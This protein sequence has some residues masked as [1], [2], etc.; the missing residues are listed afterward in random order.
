[1]TQDR[2]Y[3]NVYNVPAGLPFSKIL[4]QYLVDLSDKNGVSLTHY[5][6][7]LPTRRACRVLRDAFLGLND[8]KPILLPQM[9]PIGDVD[10]DELSILTFGADRFFA[11]IPQPIPAIRRQLLLARL[12]LQAPDFAQGA[13][14]ALAL[15]KALAQFIDQIIVEGLDVADLY[16]IVPDDFAEHWK[17]TLDF[18]KIIS[19]QWPMILHDEG[20]VDVARRRNL[21]LLSLCDF[22]RENPPDYP[23]IAAGVTGSVP[24]VSELL[25]VIANM[26]FGQVI[27]PG[28][29]C[30]M[31]DKA[32]TCLDVNHPQYMLKR[33]L[34]KIGVVR[35]DVVDIA[36]D[37]DGDARRFL[38]SQMMLPAQETHQ[39]RAFAESH[40]LKSMCSD[41]Q[42]YPCTTQGEEAA[43]IS[44]IMRQ[45][46]NVAGQVT[47]LVTPDRVLA[48]RVAAQCRQW[49]IDV[50]DS[51]GQSL[52]DTRLGKFL[53]LISRVCLSDYDP[54]SIL[55]LLKVSY[56]RFGQE[57]QD[58]VRMVELFENSVLR[59]DVS[60][61]SHDMLRSYVKECGEDGEKL[62]CFLGAF[63]DVLMPL[64][65]CRKS[66]DFKEILRVHLQVAEALA[67]SSTVLGMEIL[68]QGD[69]GE[70]GSL[71]FTDLLLHADQLGGISTG[72]Y[73]GLVSSLM[74]G[75]SVRS[76]YNVHPR[77]LIL[78]QLEA[79]LADFDTVIMGGLNE[80]VWPQDVGH[81]PWMSR[82]MRKAYGLPDAEQMIGV[83]AHDFVQAFCAKNVFMTRAGKIDGAPTVPARWLDRLDAVLHGG[84]V[85][86]GDL[87]VYPYREWAK[88]L[89]DHEDFQPYERPSPRPPVSVRPNGVSITKFETWMQNP[90][91]IYMH[92]ILR[93]R[94]TSPLLQDNDA[95]LRGTLT[96]KI[97]EKFCNT[98]PIAL[99]DDAQNI[100]IDIAKN[101]LRADVESTESLNY[102]WPKFMRL[103]QWFVSH[104]KEWR[105][106]A[107]FLASEV[108]GN[109]DLDI[110]GE[111][112]NIYGVADRIDRMHG[113]Y[114]LI[115][116]KTGAGSLSGS[117]IKKG[118]L[119]QLPL[120]AFILREGGF[121]GRGFKYDPPEMD[122]VRVPA[123]EVS[124][125][126]YW[127]LSGKG[128]GGQ[129]EDVRDDLDQIVD[130][131]LDGVI[132]LVRV[133][134]K[135]DTP[136]LC[137]PNTSNLPRFNDY[138]HVSRLKEWA[139]LDDGDG[140]VSWE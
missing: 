104:E 14:H 61:L 48:R 32:W 53:T 70:S 131:V 64:M 54:V 136:Y 16:K 27:L 46:L 105:K 91:A 15:A 11:D 23:I 17:I 18:L 135:F 5:R 129:V 24:A 112:F 82:P 94:K 121:N 33:L 68:W 83:A 103:S 20:C 57:E 45:A 71:F 1:M 88:S 62:S 92:Y 52:A 114:A 90:Y 128:A 73:E 36:E 13:D 113:G 95:A 119:P 34:N 42:Y 86:I 122:P 79:R 72:E 115:D 110:D 117:K 25:S 26:R 102:W 10:E 130:N 96:H 66:S 59:K 116:Y 47:A 44:L 109:V 9:S 76:A 134:R 111:G 43:V 37:R 69:A 12:I 98:Y 118:Q 60:I 140:E 133:F 30:C 85:Y 63:Y 87:A 28:V 29:D 4:A 123:G 21:L 107:K 65:S 120:E 81:D 67:A 84:G 108:W 2:A 127:I 3:R 39:W 51:A 99:P 74:R 80:G 100:L 106:D 40:D 138:E 126:G 101:I 50:D 124:Y 132:A 56:C 137:V 58:Y 89:N 22:W 125:M 7:L 6:V 97:V 19:E 77:I 75:V 93:L 31:S 38:A 139:A 8:G 35:G 49:G 55:S 78:G 41:L